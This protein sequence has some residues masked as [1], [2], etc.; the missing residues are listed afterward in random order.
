M[1]STKRASVKMPTIGPI[2]IPLGEIA[3]SRAVINPA[4][5]TKP[6]CFHKYWKETIMATPIEARIV[7]EKGI[8]MLW[9]KL[10]M[11]IS[12][13]AQKLAITAAFIHIFLLPGCIRFFGKIR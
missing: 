5:H 7:P 3:L 1:N 11:I 10:P 2:I 9:K 6:V 4:R 8:R 12:K 13:D